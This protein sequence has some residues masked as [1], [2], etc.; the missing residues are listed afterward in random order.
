MENQLIQV[1]S[2]EEFGTIRTILIDGV[3]Y[4][5]GK[6][7]ATALG[8]ADTD[9]AI[10]INVDDED[11]I[12]LTRK[13]FEEMALNQEPV[14][15]TVSLFGTEFGGVQ[16]IILI[17]ESGLYSL[18]FNS[19][20]PKAKEFRR[21]VTSKVLPSI[22]K[23]GYYAVPNIDGY[24]KRRLKNFLETDKDGDKLEGALP[25]LSSQCAQAIEKFLKDFEKNRFAAV[26]AVEDLPGEI[27]RDIKGYK[28][29]YQVSN[30]GRAKSFY[31][32]KATILT[33][34][35]DKHGYKYVTL[36]KNGKHKQKRLNRLV[37]EAFIPNPQKFS[38]VH[39]KDNN[40]ANNDASNLEWTTSEGNK[41]YAVKD[42]R[43]KSGEDHPHA[44][45][46]EEQVLEICKV[47]IPRHPEF[48]QAALAR[49]FGV[50]KSTI[51]FII[52][53]TN[54]KYT[55]TDEERKCTPNT[56]K[57]PKKL[58]EEQ[59]RFIR[60]NYIPRDPEFGQ[61][62]LSRRFGVS[63]AAVELVVQGKNWKNLK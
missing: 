60:E 20:L 2:N 6:D 57:K 49:K 27:W 5:V 39:H 36:S 15:E 25:A 12:A 7:V 38:V 11:K 3:P 55:G 50:S 56:A 63:R 32:G 40:P 59:V 17:N 41:N 44:K 8:Y 30:R 58:T 43:Y 19:K 23:Y 28:G 26:L 51:R 42:R 31:F 45:L 13:Q 21:W 16:R 34:F 14:Q 48:G 18:I 4:F 22:R 52:T 24:I 35:S 46:T 29:M 1:F 9:Q 33:Q 62:A 10:R 37:A 47:Y 53:G 61:G 54:W